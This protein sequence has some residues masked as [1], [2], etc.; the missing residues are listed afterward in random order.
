[1]NPRARSAFSGLG[2]AA[3]ALLVLVSG[4]CGIASVGIL[5]R[6]RWGHRVAVGLISVNLVG[7]A[8]NAALGIEPRAAVGV[9]I[10]GALLFYLLSRRVRGYFGGGNGRRED[11]PGARTMS[12]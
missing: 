2:V 8:V 11:E 9:P 1:M 5:R 4:A 12:R 3:P 7:D 6:R 10:A